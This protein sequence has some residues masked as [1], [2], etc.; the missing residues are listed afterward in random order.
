MYVTNDL[1]LSMKDDT[2]HTLHLLLRMHNAS[3]LNGECLDPECLT[4]KVLEELETRLQE[5][6]SP[7]TECG[8]LLKEPVGCC[9]FFRK[10]CECVTCWVFKLFLKN[11]SSKTKSL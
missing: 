5:P 4:C 7:L 8:S 10:L 2:S 3:R 1:T 9:S 6:L 11:V